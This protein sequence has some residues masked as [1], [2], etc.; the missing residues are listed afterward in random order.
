MAQKLPTDDGSAPPRNPGSTSNRGQESGRGGAS[1]GT[2][3]TKEPQIDRLIPLV[4]HHDSVLQ[5]YRGIFVASQSILVSVTALVIQFKPPIQFFALIFGSGL[6]VLWIWF[7]VTTRRW[8]DVHFLV[9]VIKEIED[10]RLTIKKPFSVMEEFRA[11][12]QF[13][14]RHVSE[15][16]GYASTVADDKHA[17]R[18]MQFGLTGIFLLLWL[19]LL[20]WEVILVLYG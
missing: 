15:L 11:R 17:G 1:S 4:L 7:R 13:E 9:W 5:A 10:G 16:P 8:E 19:G 3:G 2:G 12:R 6:I 18:Y 20:T 14:G